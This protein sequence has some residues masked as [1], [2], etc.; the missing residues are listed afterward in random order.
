M[1][2]AIRWT[3]RALMRLDDVGAHISEDDPAAAARVIARLVSTVDLLA[4]QPAMG[5]PGRIQGTRE[6]VLADIPYIVPYRVTRGTVEILTA[7][8]AAQR[9]P[10]RL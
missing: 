9:W 4:Q 6:L 5:R 10:E 3:R 2:R 7:M 1:S 8:H